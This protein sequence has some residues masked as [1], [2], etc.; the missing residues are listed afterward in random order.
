M[1]NDISL[2]IPK[3]EMGKSD[4]TFEIKHDGKKLGRVKISKGGV[5]Y[6][7]K[8]AKAPYSMTWVQFDKMIKDS[9]KA[10]E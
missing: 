6:Y 9:F 7:V 10:Q 8:N 5:D 2:S 1:G 3:V 4:A